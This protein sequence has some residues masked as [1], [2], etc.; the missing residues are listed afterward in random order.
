MNIEQ[1]QFLN[2]TLVMAGFDPKEDDFEML[3]E[4]FKDNLYVLGRINKELKSWLDSQFKHY[5]TDSD[6]KEY[7][8]KAKTLI[9]AA[10]ASE[11][12]A[13]YWV[14]PMI[15]IKMSDELTIPFYLST[16]LWNKPWVPEGKFYPVFWIW[17]DWRLNKWA[18]SEINNYY[19]SPL[20]AAI[21]KELDKRVKNNKINVSSWWSSNSEFEEK[22]NLW[23]SPIT[24]S[25]W[26]YDNIN[27]TLKEVAKIKASD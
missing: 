26:W 11:D 23:K 5:L 7:N 25:K 15:V 22:I 17:N 3:K 18:E 13:K 2:D 1:E 12:Y 27:D 19:G 16:W 6:I 8:D 24:H 14:R 4:E 21:A 20:L 10:I 9:D